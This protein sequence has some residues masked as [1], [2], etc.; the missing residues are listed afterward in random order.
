MTAMN[1]HRY[2]SPSGGFA[3]GKMG[4]GA[5]ILRSILPAGARWVEY[6]ES[7]GTQWIDTGVVPASTSRMVADIKFEGSANM[8][9]GVWGSSGRFQF[10]IA[11]GMFTL[12]LGSI[13]QNVIAADT[14][15]HTF[16]LDAG[17]KTANIDGNQY[18]LTSASISFGQYAIP[19][20]AQRSTSNTPSNYCRAKLYGYKLFNNGVLVRDFIPV[21]KGTVGYLYDLV[22]GEYMP[23][24]N[25]GT[26]DFTIGPDINA[27]AI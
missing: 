14:L 1:L 27:P 10:G 23:Y 24:G 22:S 17:T 21:R 2:P 25:K 26:G 18:S 19:I 12:G 13:G 4:V 15:R 11:S 5:T 16:I 20:F 9:S 7:T 8:I 6:L 3:L